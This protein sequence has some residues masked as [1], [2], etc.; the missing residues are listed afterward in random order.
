MKEKFTS[1]DAYKVAE[2]V[3]FNKAFD[4]VEK[5]IDICSDHRGIINKIDLREKLKE[6]R[7]K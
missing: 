4:E 1:Q 3:G 2:E 5:I 7:E 6:L